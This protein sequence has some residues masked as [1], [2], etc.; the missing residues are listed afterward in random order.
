MAD[1]YSAS[2]AL[3]PATGDVV[4]GASALIYA[5]TDTAFTTPLPITDMAGVPLAALVSGPSGVYPAFKVVS[6]AT[7]VVAKAGTLI[8]PLTSEKGRQGLPGL[9]AYQVAVAN[10]YAGTEAQWLNSLAVQSSG[11]TPDPANPGFYL[12]GA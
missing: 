5:D 11:L 1:S 10:G 7:N 4:A 2:L 9:S 6:E 12:I 8:T 3:N